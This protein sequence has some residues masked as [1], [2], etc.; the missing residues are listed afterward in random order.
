[1]PLLLTV[2]YQK[3][4]GKIL[5]LVPSGNVTHRKH[6]LR[7]VSGYPLNQLA[8][9]YEE[10]EA[11]I[12]PLRDSVKTLVYGTPPV[13][14]D[15]EGNPKV[16]PIHIAAQWAQ[17]KV[18]HSLKIDFEGGMGDQILQLQAVKQLRLALPNLPIEIGIRAG[19]MQIL[20]YLDH[21]GEITHNGRPAPRMGY[22]FYVNQHTSFISDPR[23]GLF[24]K[25]SLYGAN[26]GLHRVD[27]FIKLQIPYSDSALWITKA[28]IDPD[29]IRRPI[30]GIHIR[31]GSGGAKS[32]NHERAL[33]LADRWHAAT[34]GTTYLIG[35]PKDYGNQHP[36]T[37]TTPYAS[38]WMTAASWITR[39]AAMV[40]IDSGPM[41]LALAA[42][43][44]TIILWGGTGPD[45]ILGRLQ[46]PVDI[47]AHLPCIDNICYAC[48]HGNALCM[49]AIT[50][51]QAWSALAENFPEVLNNK[52]APFYTS[53]PQ[54]LST[55]A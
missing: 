29:T 26:L 17:I 36:H 1:M 28:G 32:W 30:L 27:Q 25:A 34:D 22:H 52:L 7:Y 33:A 20:P 51:Q 44:P 9:Y 50:P 23:G 18:A 48:P 12:D 4:T 8:F 35:N 10:Q 2:I 31:S 55:N 54:E 21:H 5:N 46:S 53:A 19:F 14:C 40:A 41:H 37:F 15:P 42:G 43:I 6:L 3:S 11:P 13:L 47:R 49:K 24:G 38:N 45:N 16:F 39:L